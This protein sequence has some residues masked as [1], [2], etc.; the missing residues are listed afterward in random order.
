MAAHAGVGDF[1]NSVAVSSLWLANPESSLRSAYLVQSCW[2]IENS[3][4]RAGAGY[5]QRLHTFGVFIY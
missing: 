2:F 1:H 5:A 3:D 4:W